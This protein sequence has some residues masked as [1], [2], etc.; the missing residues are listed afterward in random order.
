VP[1]MIITHSVADVANWRTFTGERAEQ[2]SMIG[3]SDV[4]DYVA[5]DGSNSV[6][7]AADVADVA[8]VLAAMAAPPPE[9]MAAMQRHGVLPP[10][11]IYVES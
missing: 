7:V 10:L 1:K 11:T 4:T 9:L 8:A 2:I 3:G 5:Q 6:A